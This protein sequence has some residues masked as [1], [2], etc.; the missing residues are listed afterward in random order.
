MSH[1]EHRP[2]ETAALQAARRLSLALDAARIGTFV[3]DMETD[4]VNADDR[5]LRLF[6]IS[7][8]DVRNRELGRFRGA[9]HP[10]DLPRVLAEI[11]AAVRERRG[12]ES[13]YRVVRGNGSIRSLLAR[14]TIEYDAAGAPARLSGAVLDITHRKRAEG[15]Q[16]QALLQADRRKDDFLATLAHELRNPL[17]PLCNAMQILELAHS[18]ETVAYARDMMSRQLQQLVRLVDDLLDLSRISRGKIELRRERIALNTAITRAAEAAEPLMAENEHELSLTLPPDPLYVDADLARLTQVFSNLL[19]NAA[20]FT[21]QGGHIRITATA[22]DDQAVVTVR[23]DGA[24]IPPD[25]LTQIFDMFVQAGEAPKQ[26]RGGLGIGLTL[27]RQLV[28]LHGGG[29]EARSAG[30]GQG[31]EFIVSLPAAMP[32]PAEPRAAGRGWRRILIVDDNKDVADSLNMLLSA[33]GRDVR[34]VYDGATAVATAAEWRPDAI[35]L[36]IGMPRM[37]GYETARRIRAQLPETK[38]V[39]IALTGGSRQDDEQRSRA[40]GFQLHLVKPVDPVMLEKLVAASGPPASAQ[41][42]EC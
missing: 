21:P 20:K 2:L 25:K 17:T 33:M 9:V 22:R 24:G 5:A 6:D 28:E 29:I 10:D 34:T 42:E 4:R 3:W 7:P 13:E 23:D 32:L 14:G 38:T 11:D 37:N 40:T 27:V 15:A 30:S 36:D 16:R 35:F 39:L 41:L 12:Y 26:P 8:D 19:T 1:P 31:S 18:R